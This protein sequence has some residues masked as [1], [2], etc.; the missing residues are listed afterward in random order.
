M[1]FEDSLKALKASYGLETDSDLAAALGLDKTAISKWRK[2]QTIPS[3]YVLLISKD[4]RPETHRA[5][6]DQYIGDLFLEIYEACRSEFSIRD[7]ETTRSWWAGRMVIFRWKIELH[8]AKLE[9]FH[10]LTAAH[11]ELRKAIMED[12][13][14]FDFIDKIEK[15]ALPSVG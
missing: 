8:W 5:L 9:T 14:P 12:G 15:V 3:R 6:V 1:S 13:D 2:R 10:Q 4:S 11:R 7:A